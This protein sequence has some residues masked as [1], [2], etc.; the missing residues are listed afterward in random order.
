MIKNTLNNKLKSLFTPWNLLILIILLIAFLLRTYRIAELLDFHYDQGR[1]AKVIWDLWHSGKF[2]LIGPTTGLNG[3]FLGPF[4]YYLIAPF[5]LIGGGNPA[6]PSLFLSFLVTLSLF[7]LYKAGELIADKWLGFIALIIGTFSN[8]FIFSGRWLSNPTPIYLSSIL[9]F[10]LMLRIIKSNNVK[11]YWWYLIYLLVGISLHF[12]AASAFFYLPVLVIFT[13]WNYKKLSIKKF[14]ISSLFLLVTFL[15][16]I[17]FNF[18]HG[19]ILFNNFVNEFSTGS[20]LQRI[21][22]LMVYDRL[23][24]YWGVFYSKIF[25]INE[26]F[27]K[28]FS[29]ISLLGI[30][31]LMFFKNNRNVLFLFL[32]FLVIPLICFTIYRGNYG[33]LYD[34]YFTGYYLIFTLLFAFGLWRIFKIKYLGLLVG[35]V[36]FLLFLKENFSLSY[37]RFRLGVFDGPNIF[38]SNQLASISWIY[39]DAGDEKF[40]VD[41]YVPP[42]IPHSFD[43][44][45]RWVGSK[46]DQDNLDKENR[47]KLLYTVYELDPPHPERLKAWMDKQDGIGNVI[48]E[49]NF[50]GVIVQKRERVKY[51]D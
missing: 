30:I 33:F 21:T 22:K 45:F 28:V 18:R 38:I 40:N 17:I 11:N 41:V 42:V 6:I 14:I 26:Y 15:P 3:I 39:Q 4:Y 13:I 43:Y 44:L 29:L 9:I 1:D 16:Q 32:V 2:F 31:G 23:I 25:P 10:Y 24:L 48:Y 27:A 36:F 46:M 19:N 20:A 34:Y 35:L 50:G 47:L 37:A 8:Y 12:E 51:E 5:Y 49:E 7:V